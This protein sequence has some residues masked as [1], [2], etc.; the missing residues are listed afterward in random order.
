MWIHAVTSIR[1]KRKIQ[2]LE[3]KKNVKILLVEIFSITD[4]F[5]I[6]EENNQSRGISQMIIN[7]MC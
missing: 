5:W 1:F 2:D 7:F 4:L 6:E 3:V